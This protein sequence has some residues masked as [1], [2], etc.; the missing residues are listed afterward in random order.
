MRIDAVHYGPDW[1]QGGW[2][3][4]RH[5]RGRE[6]GRQVQSAISGTAARS[7]GVE[8]VKAED[9]DG[10]SY[11]TCRNA[12]A[13]RRWDTLP[14]K[15]DVRGLFAAMLMVDPVK[16]R[17]W[18]SGRGLGF[19]R[20]PPPTLRRFSRSYGWKCSARAADR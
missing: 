14:L 20:D 8:I 10:P 13:I 5:D 4:R 12:A 16:V 1:R 11:K 7:M 2:A 6:L 3:Q 9:W 19:D 17:R 15:R 18:A